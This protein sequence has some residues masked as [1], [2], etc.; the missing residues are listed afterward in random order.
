MVRHAGCRIKDRIS[1]MS[2]SFVGLPSARSRFLYVPKLTDM[3][4]SLGC[5]AQ[6][7]KW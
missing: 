5:P 3:T 7:W 4:L 6:V 2:R 1:L